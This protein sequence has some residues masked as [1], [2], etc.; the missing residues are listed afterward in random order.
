MM[1][2]PIN[3]PDPYASD[4]PTRQVLDRIGDK[5]TTLIIGLLGDEAKRFSELQRGIQGISHKML[6]QTLRNL[7]RD[8]LVTR[9]V[10]AEIPPRVEYRLTPLGKTLFE[11]ITAIIRW[12]EDHIDQVSAAQEAYDARTAEPMGG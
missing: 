10:Y 8:G 11:L 7:E 1:N 12:S 2:D 6:T 3:F 5:W 9:T 4:C